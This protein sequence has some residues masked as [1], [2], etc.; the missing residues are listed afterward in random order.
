VKIDTL[1]ESSRT[2]TRFCGWPR[3]RRRSKLEQSTFQG[4]RH[5]SMNSRRRRFHSRKANM[6]TRLMPC[7]K[8]W[9][10]HSPPNRQQLVSAAT[11]MPGM[12]TVPKKGGSSPDKISVHTGPLYLESI[13]SAAQS[14][15]QLR[16]M[17]GQLRVDKDFLRVTEVTDG[18]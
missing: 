6:T 4:R 9:A 1:L 14:A 13:H 7:R 8:P 12:V 17:C 10:A 11:E 5:G 3:R 18:P 2:A 15:R 16:A